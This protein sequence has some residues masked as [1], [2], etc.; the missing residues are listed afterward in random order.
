MVIP[1]FDEADRLPDTLTSLARC[2]ALSELGATL[3]V[4]VV[5]DGSGDGTGERAAAHPDAARLDLRVV[6]HVANRGK[7]AAVRSGFAASRGD[8]VLL[9]DADHA[10]PFEE[11]T[12]LA[13]HAAA[14]ALAI[15]SRAL[16]RRLIEHRQPW[17]RDMMG[18]AFNLV[19][20]TVAVPGILDTQC[21]FKLYPGA[22]AR[23]LAEVQGSDGFAFDV[24]HLVV[25]RWWGWPVVEQP[26]RWRHVEASRVRA[27]RHSIEMLRTTLGLAFNAARG[28]LPTEPEL[29]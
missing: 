20:R 18:R 15:G 28:R 26:V 10:T 1:A 17:Y 5:D 6:A 21:G 9:A 16:D 4:V 25:A 14:G 27:G 19:V 7:G 2:D 11:I 29:A 8:L 12:R 3:E 22:L 23:R 24:E 13:P